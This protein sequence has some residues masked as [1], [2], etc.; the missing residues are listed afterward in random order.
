MIPH[1][2]GPISLAALFHVLGTLPVPVVTE[3]AGGSPR[4]P[5]HLTAGCRF[6]NG[7]LWPEAR[8]GLGVEIDPAGAEL[9]EEITEH[10]APIPLY[11][12][13]DGSLTNW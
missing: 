2:T 10:S 6:E 13:P 1:F 11:F 8:P 3:I 12:R 9:V 5:A 7:K 4:L